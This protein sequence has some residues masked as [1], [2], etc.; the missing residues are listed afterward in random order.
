MKASLPVGRNVSSRRGVSRVLLA[1]ACIGSLA[2]SACQR[3][4]PPPA[5][6]PAPA[7]APAQR[8]AAPTMSPGI[9]SP[10]TLCNDRALGPLGEAMGALDS[11][12]SAAAILPA[13]AK[14]RDGI[15]TC[16]AQMTRPSN[17]ATQC[18]RSARTS[19]R[20]VETM[21]GAA[22]P[23]RGTVRTQLASADRRLSGCIST[24]L[25]S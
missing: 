8:A 20:R 11:G 1:V 14:V 4:T 22:N 10:A 19:I 12:Q 17:A 6:A 7:A 23:N 24:H 18:F 13:L 2:V 21:L 25:R 3:D 9:N 15:D 5:P 16:V